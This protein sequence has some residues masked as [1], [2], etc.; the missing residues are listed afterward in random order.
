MSLLILFPAF[1]ATVFSDEP[2][3]AGTAA[4]D[5]PAEAVG[6]GSEVVEPSEAEGAALGDDVVSG[7]L[8]ELYQLIREAPSDDG[9]AAEDAEDAASV[10]GG[11][12]L[13]EEGGLAEGDADDEFLSVAAL[14][15]EP[16]GGEFQTFDAALWQVSFVAPDGVRA[17]S[18]Q[19]VAEGGLA[20][21][22]G[23]L[24]LPADNGDSRYVSFLG[25]YL[26]DDPSPEDA[27]Y[28]FDSPVTG[29]LTLYAAYSKYWLASFLTS[30][31]I[32]TPSGG[33]VFHTERAETGRRVTSAGA[34]AA[35]AAE[36]HS[37]V[38][39]WEVYE[40]GVGWRDF[41]FDEG[42]T[43]DIFLRPV[44][45]HYVYFISDGAQIS[46]ELVRHGGAATEPEPLTKGGYVF[47]GWALASPN[48]PQYYFDEPV[49]E[50]L[51]LYA[52]WTGGKARLEVNFWVEKPNITSAGVADP[53]QDMRYFNIF[54]SETYY[55]TAGAVID[56]AF[57]R[58]LAEPAPAGMPGYFAYRDTVEGF[59][60][61]YPGGD[62]S[63]VLDLFYGRKSYRVEFR[64]LESNSSMTIGGGTYSPRSA[65]YS[66]SA[67]IGDSI[68][69]V[70]PFK[71]AVFTKG[72]AIIA[73]RG[74]YPDIPNPGMPATDDLFFR[75]VDWLTEDVVDLAIPTTVLYWIGNVPGLNPTHTLSYYF[76]SPIGNVSG[77]ILCDGKYYI[78]D[79]TLSGTVTKPL[80]LVPALIQKIPGYIS[81]ATAVSGV[82]E[83]GAF[84]KAQDLDLLNQCFFYD[85]EPVTHKLIL[86]YM[87]GTPAPGAPTGNALHLS[88]GAPIIASLA[89][90]PTPTRTDDGGTVRA[91]S[92]WSYYEGGAETVLTAGALMPDH[93]L[94]LYA[95][96]EDEAAHEA[97]NVYAYDGLPPGG[98]TAGS[99]QAP[100]GSILDMSA[101]PYALGQPHPT[102]PSLGFLMGWK[103]EKNGELV[104]YNFGD[105]VTRDLRLYA[106]WRQKTEFYKVVYRSIDP[107]VQGALPSDYLF[108]AAGTEARVKYNLTPGGLSHV[109]GCA[110][111]GWRIA[112]GGLTPGGVIYYEGTILTLDAAA[113]AKAA[114]GLDGWKEIVLTPV[115]AA[116]APPSEPPPV[117][118]PEPPDL[119]ALVEVAP[120]VG[121]YDA[122]FH[123]VTVTYSGV[124]QPVVEYRVAT[125]AAWDAANPLYRDV[126]LNAS[127]QAVSYPVWVR[128]E[129]EGY[130]PFLTL[131]SVTISPAALYVKAPSASVSRGSYPPN[132]WTVTY[133]GFV[134][135]EGPSALSGAALITVP[136]FV[137][138][139]AGT[140]RVDAYG[141]SSA[142]YAITYLS[143]LLTVR[144][145][146]I[147]PDP[148]DPGDG[149][150]PGG[151]GDEEPP[152]GGGE[153]PGGET[154][155]GA[156]DIPPTQPPLTPPIDVPAEPT[157]TQPPPVRPPVKPPVVITPEQPPTEPPVVT[158]VEPPVVTPV[159]PP[160]I[161]IP[162]EPPPLAGGGAWALLNLI[163]AILGALTALVL[164]VT[165]FFRKREDEQER[166]KEYSRQA[167]PSGSAPQEEQERRERRLRALWRTLGIICGILGPIVFILTE[168][169]RLPMIF[170]D[171]WTL[172]MVVIDLAVALFTWLT[173]KRNRDD[174]EY[175]ERGGNFQFAGK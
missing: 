120:Y 82:V 127:S 142:N 151:G 21:N 125:G 78:K 55:I 152:G 110:F 4:S 169:M 104:W 172:L 37:P 28:D 34:V 51:S 20:E 59:S 3:M 96:Y 71:N 11:D 85:L 134:G 32:S 26:D 65:L 42:I 155:G 94:T 53:A 63:A 146:Y 72:G 171:R 38:T 100:Y 136:A 168:D 83:D 139:T 27:P 156:V 135:G 87:G 64:L 166:S 105:P 35:Y 97:L 5:T 30:P 45:S 56:A 18:P 1:P 41:D 109:S 44:I 77:A 102:D 101:L 36:P 60:V 12:G 24:P 141:L 103:V 99:L 39:G 113:L 68:S 163:L 118:P 131:S 40:D 144:G 58:A 167:A 80:M 89:P 117:E 140:F 31:A 33:G 159:E 10:L 29:D 43:E 95:S 52:S 165:A 122:L 15:A 62:G 112:D 164:L 74:W 154:S 170:T 46:S 91:F 114:Q 75:Q 106:V 67:K 6:S 69:E 13:S 8:T 133:A 160:P 161:T 116:P 119:G 158:P 123:S 49:T 16:F 115:F 66:I 149:I 174:R 48:G 57:A 93:A 76:E 175:D 22:P 108:Y 14:G 150:V 79:E 25:W 70:W 145:G 98:A 126:A 9:A 173:Y 162:S 130:A 137:F 73:F 23:R 81:P 90:Y 86:N 111:I 157:P 17:P 88:P 124:G 107:N 147:P 148:T 2:G 138:N 132:D 128:V 50:S 47:G 92:H 153:E 61:S 84:I 129:V 19:A 143:G 54:A 7:S 121:Y